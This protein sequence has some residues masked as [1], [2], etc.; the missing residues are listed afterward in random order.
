MRCC[1]AC[2]VAAPNPAR[3]FLMMLWRFGVRLR[4]EADGKT[5]TPYDPEGRVS[6]LLIEETQ[7]RSARI[8]PFVAKYI[9]HQEEHCATLEAMRIPNVSQLGKRRRREMEQGRLV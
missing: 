4:I 3:R 5:V 6:P 1:R 7:K 2:D 8:L 9:E